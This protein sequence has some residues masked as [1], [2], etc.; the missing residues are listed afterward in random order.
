[1]DNHCSRSRILCGFILT[2]KHIGQQNSKTWAWIWLQHIHDGF[3]CLRNLS[4]GNG[5]KHPMV[6]RIV[7]KQNFCRFNENGYQRKQSP[8]YQHIDA[9][10]Q[11]RQNSAH[12]RPNSHIAQ[13]S[14]NHT[15][16]SCWKIVNQHLKTCRHMAFHGLI[17]F[18][19]TKTSQRSHNHRCHQHGNICVAHNRANYSDSSYHTPPVAADHTASRRRNQNGNQIGQ[20]RADH[21]AETFVGNPAGVNKQCSQKTKSN[22]SPNI[23]HN[24]SR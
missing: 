22:Q 19:N 14:Q 4:S 1:M 6:N 12:N 11:N 23:G 18:L 8:L 24:H 9:G 7:E 13:H 5:S 16:Q 10:R 2:K 21:A 15:N 3:P 20:H 17:K